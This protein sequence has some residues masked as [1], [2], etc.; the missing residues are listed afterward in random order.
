MRTKVWYHSRSAHEHNNFYWKLAKIILAK[1]TSVR[2]KCVLL[3]DT[4][5]ARASKILRKHTR[6]SC[7]RM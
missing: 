6:L 2:E 1:M 4:K 7:A 3:M 5:V